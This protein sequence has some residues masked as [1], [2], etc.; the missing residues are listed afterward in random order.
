MKR[1]FT[2]GVSA[3]AALALQT[4]CIAEESPTKKVAHIDNCRVEYKTTAAPE[5]VSEKG[6][7][8]DVEITTVVTNTS[9]GNIFF[10]VKSYLYPAGSDKYIAA[11]A[12]PLKIA[13]SQT[14]SV[15]QILKAAASRFN[16]AESS[17][18][19][20]TELFNFDTKETVDTVYTEV[21][22]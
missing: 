15:T 12:K 13:A 20:K 11:N 2:L 4:V 14:D 7:W 17:Y 1:L 6:A 21:G 16:P 10:K 22:R 18:V 19:I 9:D 8:C 5:F 3:L